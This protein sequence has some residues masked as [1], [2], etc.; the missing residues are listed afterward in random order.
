[1]KLNNLALIII[2]FIIVSFFLSLLGIVSLAF[3]DILAYS[4][5]V[6]GVALVYTETIRQNKISIFLGTIIFLFGVYFLITENFNL[7]PNKE[8]YLPILLIFCGSGLLLV[9]L[10]TQVTKIYLI[11][12]LILIA[13]GMTFMIVNQNLAVKIFFLSLLPVL[14]LL[15]PVLIIL[16]VLFFLMRV[17]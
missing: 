16:V 8:F 1:M 2:L 14:K 4:L 5:L 6:I 11:G 17:K 10:L 7:N 3:T 13:G 15:W 12:S 9:Y